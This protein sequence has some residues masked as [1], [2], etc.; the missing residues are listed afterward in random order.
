[1]DYTVAFHA[2]LLEC[3]NI[4]NAEALDHY[5][6]GLKPMTQDWV[7][8]H[9]PTS[10]HQAAKW[11]ER[12]DNTYF[13]KQHTAAASSTNPG[14]GNPPG[15]WWQSWSSRNPAKNLRILASAHSSSIF[16]A[17]S[18]HRAGPSSN[19]KT[20]TYGDSLVSAT[21]VVAQ[22]TKHQNVN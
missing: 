15:N 13:S 18:K 9:D 22:G 1:M 20:R 21:S 4:S 5:F 3:S 10:M 12:Y 11:A 6:A 2:R 16:R 19:N 7:L 14:G 8:I 17:S